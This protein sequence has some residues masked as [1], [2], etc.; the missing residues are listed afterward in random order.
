MNIPGALQ[1]SH[2]GAVHRLKCFVLSEVIAP[3]CSGE[4][5]PSSPHRIADHIQR[6]GGF[7]A[8][9]LVVFE[10]HVPVGIAIESTPSAREGSRTHANH[11][12]IL[13]CWPVGPESVL[14]HV[15]ALWPHA[16]HSVGRAHNVQSRS[17]LSRLEV[18]INDL[19]S[20]LTLYVEAVALPEEETR[21]D[22]LAALN[23][24]E[25]LVAGDPVIKILAVEVDSIVDIV[26]DVAVLHCQTHATLS[27]AYSSVDMQ[28]ETLAQNQLR[29]PKVKASQDA[30][31]SSTPQKRGGVHHHTGS[32]VRE[33]VPGEQVQAG[34]EVLDLGIHQERRPAGGHVGV[35]NQASSP[36]RGQKK[37]NKE[38]AK[39][40]P[41]PLSA[42][43]GSYS[44]SRGG[45][46]S[47]IR[48][49]PPVRAVEFTALHQNGV[50][51]PVEVE[52]FETA[53]DVDVA[54][55]RAS[56]IHLYLGV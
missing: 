39:G 27:V 16:G 3:E 25:G 33:P 5:G 53:S 51:H 11:I 26:G 41:P 22:E 37:K 28:Q 50:L 42:E 20:M 2:H 4:S 52:S 32:V 18:A 44:E 14:R 38:K 43:T 56:A 8:K 10:R 31:S 12:L 7:A 13:G 40:P 49:R 48:P 34:A 29:Q 9:D 23:T 45:A 54:E 30:H 17:I 6:S 24:S 35:G 15:N 47:C 55:H 19:H 1:E 21:I 36:R 46:D